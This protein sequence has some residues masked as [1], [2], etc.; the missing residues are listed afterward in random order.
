[1]SSLPIISSNVC[2]RYFSILKYHQKVAVVEKQFFKIKRLF[3]SENVT[4]SF[5]GQFISNYFSELNI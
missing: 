3:G 5:T 4:N 1:M 2:G